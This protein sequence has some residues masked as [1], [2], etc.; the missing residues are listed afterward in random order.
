MMLGIVLWKQEHLEEAASAFAKGLAVEPNNL[1]LLS[2]DME[3]ALAQRDIARLIRRVAV[4]MPQVTPKDELYAIVP[5]LSWLANPTPGW[6]HVI[7]AISTLEPEVKFTWD[8]SDTARAMNYLDL[9]ASTQQAARHFIDFFEGR[10]NLSTLRERLVAT[11]K[12]H[13]LG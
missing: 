10:I 13:R 11:Q 9:N 3:L 5:F 1:G 2:N 6:G 7:I 12:I 4:A 8:F